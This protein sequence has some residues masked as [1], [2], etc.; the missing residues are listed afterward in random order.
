VGQVT[1]AAARV[2]DAERYELA[3]VAAAPSDVVVRAPDLSGLSVLETVEPVD[4]D[5]SNDPAPVPGGGS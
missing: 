3:A 5:P 1:V 2:E 4:A